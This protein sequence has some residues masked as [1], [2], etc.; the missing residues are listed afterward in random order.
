MGGLDSILGMLPGGDQM[1][2]MA[3]F[4]EKKIL[5]MEAIINS[6]TQAERSR[7]EIIDF[8]RR[9][10]L[11]RGS[12]TNLEEVGQLI[13][14]FSEMRKMMKRTSLLGR[15]MSGKAA[16]TGGGGRGGLMSRGSNVTPSRKKRKKGR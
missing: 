16:L 4:D 11:A 2:G 12:G 1:R 7:P 10:R 14:Q 8:P 5:H 15:L 13:R 6:M 9:R 3:G